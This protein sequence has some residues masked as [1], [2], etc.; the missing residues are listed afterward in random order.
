MHVLAD[1]AMRLFRG[2][3]DVTRHLLLHDLLC[4]KA[5]R[6]GIVIAGLHRKT[7]PVDGASVETRRCA[8]LQAASAKSKQFERLA[9]KLRWRL[10]RTPCGVG[11]LSAMNQAIEERACGD[12]HSASLNLPAIA[13]LNACSSSGAIC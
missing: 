3:S 10:T 7:R 12:D 11:L 2:E 5:E 13:Q 1:D 8:C 4:A 6:S 9:Q